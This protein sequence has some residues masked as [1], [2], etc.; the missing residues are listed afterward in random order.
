LI[1][2]Q[3][4]YDKQLTKLNSDYADKSKGMTQDTYNQ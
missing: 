3:E 1:Q 4:D 2:A